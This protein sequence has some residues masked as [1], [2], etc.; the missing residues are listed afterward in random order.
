[1]KTLI[2]IE[3]LSPPVAGTGNCSNLGLAQMSVWCLMT[4]LKPAV[5]YV[6]L[7]HPYQRCAQNAKVYLLLCIFSVCGFDRKNC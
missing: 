7:K 5:M 6:V 3:D 1:M 2:A 4:L